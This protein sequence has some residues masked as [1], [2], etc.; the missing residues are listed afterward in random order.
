METMD[1]NEHLNFAEV[2]VDRF[3]RKAFVAN[4][5]MSLRSCLP[6]RSD[7]PAVPPAENE[8]ETTF[9]FI[10]MINYVATTPVLFWDGREIKRLSP[11]EAALRFLTDPDCDITMFEPRP[12]KRPQPKAP[13]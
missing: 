10:E 5:C 7:D 6:L 11:G 2:T 4:S 12:K 3:D 13:P 1:I 8:F 9:S